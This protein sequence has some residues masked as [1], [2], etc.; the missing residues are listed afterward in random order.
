MS[1]RVMGGY[2]KGYPIKTVPGRV[3]RPTTG[4]VREAIFSILQHEVPDAEVL[5]VFSGS[6]ALA[7]EAV[8]RGA[9]SAVIIE[10]NRKAVNAIRDNLEKCDLDI[11]IIAAGYNTGFEVLSGEGKKFDLI[12]ADPPYGLV[13]PDKM[14]DLLVKYS[15]IKEG[16]Y[17]I[18]EHSGKLEPEG[19]NIVKTRR[20]GDSAITIFRNE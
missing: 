15:L 14:F 20:F 2:L 5:D 3:T 6:G 4:R 12:F 9:A 10:K 8:S 19:P 16:G 1:T 7:I 13:A 17:L 18:M 11:R